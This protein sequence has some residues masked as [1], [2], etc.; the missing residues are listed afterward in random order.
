M[1][2]SNRMFNPNVRDNCNDPSIYLKERLNKLGYELKTAD[3]NSLNDCEWVLFYDSSSV[4][5]YAGWQGI[6]KK[7]KANIVRIPLERDLYNE[8]VKAGLQKR[9]V[10]F[11]WEAPAVCRKNWDPDL[12]ELFPIIFSWHD[13]LIDNR[14]YFKT[15]ITQPRQYPQTPRIHFIQKKLLV[16]ISANKYSYHPRELYSARRASIKHFERSQT[17]NFDLYGVGWDGPMNI[18][19]KV[20]PFTRH[21]YPSFKGTIKNKWEVLPRYRFSLCYENIRD[22]PGYVTEKIFDCMRAGCVPVYWGAS[23]ICEHVSPEAFIDRRNY[24]SD[25]ELESFLLDIDEHRYLIYQEAI[26]EYLESD[27]F[28][29]YLPPAFADTIIKVLKL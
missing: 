19:E 9:S 28:K 14:K 2:N 21:V 27:L 26:K 1:G 20:F 8:C 13:G 18:Q 15:Y 22:E 23:N 10:L 17:N 12:H 16:S 25:A 3:D 29:K 7:I 4:R 11:L 6:A 24:R 5:P